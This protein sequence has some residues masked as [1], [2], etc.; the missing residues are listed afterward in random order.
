MT[1]RRRGTRQRPARSPSHTRHWPGRVRCAVI[2]VV[3]GW[4]KATR[5][6]GSLLRY[7]HVECSIGRPKCGVKDRVAGTT[8]RHW[9]WKISRGDLR[10]HVKHRGS[11]NPAASANK[12]PR[13]NASALFNDTSRERFSWLIDYMNLAVERSSF[14]TTYAHQQRPGA[15]ARPCHDLVS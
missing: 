7:L 1:Y 11:G 3:C 8:Q 6:M 12:K 9:L 4:C 13:R 5:E 14:R 10:S 15:R 2:R